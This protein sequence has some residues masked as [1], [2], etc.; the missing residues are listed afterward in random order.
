MRVLDRILQ[1]WRQRVALP[2]VPRAARLL[3]IGCYQGEFLRLLG[4]NVHDSVGMDP[5]APSLEFGRYRLLSSRFNDILDF[6]NESFDC[7][8]LLATLEHIVAKR[9]LCRECR[10]A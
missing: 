9:A 6:P 3:D 10:R 4:D 7:V 2:W 5:Y 1:M 8:T